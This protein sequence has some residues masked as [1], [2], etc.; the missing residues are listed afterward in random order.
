M[1]KVHRIQGILISQWCLMSL[2]DTSSLQHIV[3]SHSRFWNNHWI[4]RKKVAKK[5]YKRLPDFFLSSH[6][7]NS[8][9]I[10]RTKFLIRFKLSKLSWFW[11]YKTLSNTEI[12][13]WKLLITGNLCRGSLAA[14]RVLLCWR[15]VWS[16]SLARHSQISG[17]CILRTVLMTSGTERKAKTTT[18]NLKITKWWNNHPRSLQVTWKVNSYINDPGKA[19]RR[20]TCNHT[21]QNKT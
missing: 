1:T 20:F 19:S 14:C 12:S 10:A 9:S 7:C 3:Y 17:H 5:V 8:W 4:F 18:L 6:W 21:Q 11:W 2:N 15:G 16:H 13:T